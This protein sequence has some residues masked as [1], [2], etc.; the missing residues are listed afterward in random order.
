MNSSTDPESV[1]TRRRE[2]EFFIL[3][4]AFTAVTALDDCYMN[5]YCDEYMSECYLKSCSDEIASD[6]DVIK[7]HGNLCQEHRYILTHI[8]ESSEVILFDDVC[9]QIPKCQ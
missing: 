4:L 6:Y 9:E 2:M 5:C 3:F 7:I 8:T 1:K